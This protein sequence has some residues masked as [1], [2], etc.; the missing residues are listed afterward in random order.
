MRA[1]KV[2]EKYLR[3]LSTNSKPLCVLFANAS[4]NNSNGYMPLLTSGSLLAT[5]ASYCGIAHFLREQG[6]PQA[7]Y[8]FD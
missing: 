5:G 1:Q 3:V 7:C 2:V 4:D 8:T 6:F